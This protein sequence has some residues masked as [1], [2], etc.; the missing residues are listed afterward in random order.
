MHRSSRLEAS[1]RFANVDVDV[2][3]YGSPRSLVEALASRL[4]ALHVE[5]RWARLELRDGVRGGEATRMRKTLEVIL[6]ALE[7]LPPELRRWRRLELSVGWIA[8]TPREAVSVRIDA[9]HLAR[10][11]LLGAS[12]EVVV[13]AANDV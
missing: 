5:A 10:A 12:L 13:Y 1:A 6:R 7:Q 3:T 8:Q 11:A 2:H 9:T 4:F